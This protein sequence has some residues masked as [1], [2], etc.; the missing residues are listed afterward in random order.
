M[1]GRLE[2]NAEEGTGWRNVAA[3]GKSGGF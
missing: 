2:R 1:A 3:G